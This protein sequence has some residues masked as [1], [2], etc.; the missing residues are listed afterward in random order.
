MCARVDTSMYAYI[1]CTCMYARTHKL[2]FQPLLTWTPLPWAVSQFLRA[3]H[4]LPTFKGWWGAIK[5]KSSCYHYP[6]SSHS[7]VADLKIPAHDNLPLGFRAPVFLPVM[8]TAAKEVQSQEQGLDTVSSCPCPCVPKGGW[9]VTLGC[10]HRPCPASPL[11]A[12]SREETHAT[13]ACLPIKPLHNPTRPAVSPLWVWLQAL[14]GELIL[15][16]N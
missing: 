15:N 14:P 13:N 1:I 6:D 9:G 10:F 12:P 4:F 5:L 8:F 7:T 11:L 2:T 3:K 16:H